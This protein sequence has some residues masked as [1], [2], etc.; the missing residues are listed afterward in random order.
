[1]KHQKVCPQEVWINI[2]GDDY[3]AVSVYET[4]TAGDV[5]KMVKSAVPGERLLTQKGDTV[6]LC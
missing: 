2:G 6:M 1:M 3:E 4:T 5:L